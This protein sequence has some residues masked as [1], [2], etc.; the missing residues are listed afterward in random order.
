[1]II[2]RDNGMG[3]SGRQLHFLDPGQQDHVRVAEILDRHTD[4]DVLGIVD[5]T[6]DWWCAEECE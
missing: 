5:G 3:Y 6:I 4:G 2:I 1:M